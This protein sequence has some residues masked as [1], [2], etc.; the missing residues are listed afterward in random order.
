MKFPGIRT[1]IAVVIIIG[2]GRPVDSPAIL[3]VRRCA[4]GSSDQ[5]ANGADD[6]T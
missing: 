2:V 6:E 1:E 5:G 3:E 4:D